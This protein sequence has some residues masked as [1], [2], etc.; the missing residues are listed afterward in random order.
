MASNNSKNSTSGK[1]VDETTPNAENTQ[2]A[3]E[4]TKPKEE[5][6][7]VIQLKQAT[8]NLLKKNEEL[9]AQL[10]AFKQ[11]Q[12]AKSNPQSSE[13]IELLKSQV[14][15]LKG[16]IEGMGMIAPT[17]MGNMDPLKAKWARR[18]PSHKD[19]QD[20]YVTFSAR[21][22]AYV[23]TAYT[24]NN[25][26]HEAP[27]KAIEFKYAGSDIRRNGRESEVVNFCTYSTN[28]KEEI[29]FIRN[30][31][32]YGLEFSENINKV[33]SADAK[34]LNRMTAI[35][36][37]LRALPLEHLIPMAKAEG[38]DVNQMGNDDMALELSVRIAAREENIEREQVSKR[39]QENAAS[40][41]RTSHSQ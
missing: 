21:A 28:L 1:D 10:E 12:T 5:S 33:V 16:M 18:K 19:V 9:E 39:M 26:L 11:T 13:E 30:S 32:L 23:I 24:R 15:S 40:L 38:L 4:S 20:T 29:E 8:L 3:G 35:L 7:D 25:V 2:P 17:V 27:F 22:V 37:K 36:T 41:V 34:L 14:A 6:T 31:P